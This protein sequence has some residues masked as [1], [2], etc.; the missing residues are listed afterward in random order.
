MK[1][2]IAYIKPHRLSAVTLAL[3][4]IRD[5][6]G[7]SV[8]EVKGFGRRDEKDIP[9]S[10]DEL[11]DFAP[12]V[13]IEIFCKDDLADELVTVIDREARTGLR[14]DGKIYVIDVN[15]AY[16]IGKGGLQ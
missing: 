14:G 12:Y 3:Q 11:M 2:I 6:R 5:L 15:K 10:V 13:K 9:C 7:M 16:K 4:K 1:Q 8:T